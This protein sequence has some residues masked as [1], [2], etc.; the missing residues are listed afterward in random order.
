M[1]LYAVSTNNKP[2]T[3]NNSPA[4][5]RHVNVGGSNISAGHCVD[6]P[7]HASARSQMPPAGRQVV[8]LGSRELLLAQFKPLRR[9]KVKHTHDSSIRH[10]TAV[11][12][13]PSHVDA[14]S[15][16]PTA[17]RHT[18]P[19]G[20]TCRNTH[21][22]MSTTSSQSNHAHTQTRPDLADNRHRHQ[23]NT[24]AHRMHWCRCC[25]PF[26]V[27]TAASAAR[28]RRRDTTPMSRCTSRR[29][30]REHRYQRGITQSECE[31]A[32]C[33]RQ[34]TSHGPADGRQ[35]VLLPSKTSAGQAVVVPA[36]YSAVSHTPCDGR[37]QHVGVHISHTHKHARAHSPHS[38]HRHHRR[39]GTVTDHTIAIGRQCTATNWR[40]TELI[41]I[42]LRMCDNSIASYQ[43]CRL[44]L[45]RWTS[46]R[47]NHQFTMRTRTRTP[48]SRLTRSSAVLSDVAVRDGW[49][50]CRLRRQPLV[51]RACCALPKHAHVSS[52]NALLCEVLP[53]PCMSRQHRTRPLTADTRC[54]T[55]P[56][57][58]TNYAKTSSHS[59][60]TDT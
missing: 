58:R 12:N 51:G 26:A 33:T 54:P 3:T 18:A 40:A 9:E 43:C 29:S 48:L 6:M 55:T 37:L 35:T 8:P 53:C 23:C 34:R 59:T 4:T 36:Q 7:E 22:Q 1:H 24:L 10:V 32:Q 14:I 2:Y 45:V 15:H 11:T 47:Y 25:T 13:L 49:P 38:S 30:A 56:T 21:D 57:A 27:G 42:S 44:K 5:G 28:S 31:R 19:D 60:H 41:R 50:A 20:C 17:G 16:E 46:G 52:N 39:G